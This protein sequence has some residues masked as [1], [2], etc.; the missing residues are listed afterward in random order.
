MRENGARAQRADDA[1]AR[2]GA[3]AFPV[4]HGEF[5]GGGIIE[6]GEAANGD[7][8]EVAVADELFANAAQPAVAAGNE[9]LDR[10]PPRG[11]V[12]LAV[13]GERADFVE[14]APVAEDDVQLAH[15]VGE[16]GNLRG[17]LREGGPVCG[18]GGFGGS[19]QCGGNAAC[20]AAGF[21]FVERFHREREQAVEPSRTRG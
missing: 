20:D 12:G 10:L 3:E 8:R 6:C 18:R 7:G 4:S 21:C 16:G 11:E 2:V 19:A 17:L 15:L 13:E 14:R 5:G 9:R 1:G